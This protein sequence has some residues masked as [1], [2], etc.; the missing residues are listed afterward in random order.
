[1][2]QIVCSSPHIPYVPPDGWGPPPPSLPYPPLY[3]GFRGVYGGIIP[4]IKFSRKNLW[5]MTPLYIKCV[6]TQNKIFG[7]ILYLL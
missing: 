7:K 2:T 1:M 4:S 6:G 3:R 5:N